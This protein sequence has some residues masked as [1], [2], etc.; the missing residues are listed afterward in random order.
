MILTPGNG[1][2]V[3]QDGWGLG[4]RGES[5]GQGGQRASPPF[6]QGRVGESEPDGAEEG[7]QWRNLQNP[8]T[9]YTATGGRPVVVQNGHGGTSDGLDCSL[10]W[11]DS[12]PI[13]ILKSWLEAAAGRSG[14]GAWP[15]P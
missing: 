1:K 10:N 8:F 9:F 13:G 4:L 7:G 14:I 5:G 6:G 11:A 3:R 12:G 2:G 15:I